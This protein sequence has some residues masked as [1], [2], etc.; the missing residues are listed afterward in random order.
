MFFDLIAVPD[1]AV[2][3][4]VLY[5]LEL[6]PGGR[7]NRHPPLFCMFFLGGGGIRV[8]AV[9]ELLENSGCD[10]SNWLSKRI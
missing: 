9:V 10:L 3:Y 5:N 8:I 1:V 4:V 6:F 7:C 2:C